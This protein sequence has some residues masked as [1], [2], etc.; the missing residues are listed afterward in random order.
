[1]FNQLKQ[2]YPPPVANR[3][4][5]LT[6]VL[7]G[8]FIGLFLILFEPFNLNL[9]TYR[10]KHLALLFFGIITTAVLFLSLYILPKLL[11][12]LFSEQKWTVLH[13]ILFY[14]AILFAIATLN[15]IYT[16]YLNNL[17]F[18]WANYWWI[19]NRTFL[20]GGI[21]IAFLTIL[22]HNRK[23]KQHYKDAEQILSGLQTL[24]GIHEEND[25]HITTDL[26]NETISIKEENFLYAMAVGNYI[27][28]YSVENDEIKKKT[29]R[30]SLG[31]L[32]LQLLS[33]R[34]KR[35]HRSYLVNLNKV[36]G[37]SGNAQG[38]KLKLTD[39]SGNIPVS[40]KY[41]PDIK[42]NLK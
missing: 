24:E 7:F 39:L 12:D 30:V 32:E 37:V 10:F 11:P 27:E 15:G 38:L 42:N 25:W 40:R 17:Q 18:S 14:T 33:N 36:E 29:Y 22:D 31:S 9:S 3:R 5:I 26:K 2:S 41:I 35:C 19:I 16:N 20:L 8:L 21:P 28:L 4:A 13:H 6:S 1:M 34:L 23:L